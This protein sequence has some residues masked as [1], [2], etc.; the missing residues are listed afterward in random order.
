MRQDRPLS[1]AMGVPA[2]ALPNLRALAARA[3][4][5][6][7]PAAGA[8]VRLNKWQVPLPDRAIAACDA[9]HDRIGRNDRKLLTESGRLAFR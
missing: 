4:T 6:A 8:P 2:P 3:A 7:F 5:G 1:L 9:E